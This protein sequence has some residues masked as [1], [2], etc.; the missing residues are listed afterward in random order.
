MKQVLVFHN[1]MILFW[2]NLHFQVLKDGK[3]I[4]KLVFVCG[5]HT[6]SA[7]FYLSRLCSILSIFF[8]LV[9]SI[10]SFCVIS[11]SPC[12]GLMI[13]GLSLRFVASVFVCRCFFSIY[14]VHY[15]V[16]SRGGSRIS[17]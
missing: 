5:V 11:V 4:C 14:L 2:L 8:V 12:F 6:A 7:L 17:S 16:H 13:S 15:S 3:N 9:I 1:R 10:V